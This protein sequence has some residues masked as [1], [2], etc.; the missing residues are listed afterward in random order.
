[1]IPRVVYDTN[2]IIS[3]LFWS[4][5]SRRLLKLAEQSKVILFSSLDTE[6]ELVRVLQYSKFGLSFEESLRFLIYYQSISARIKVSTKINIIDR[7]PSDNIFLE[8]AIDSFA[9]YIVSGDH[10]LLDLGGY[11]EIKII[12]AEQFL[13]IVKL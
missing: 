12:T 9:N 4:G 13:K 7:D 10:H 8:C 3:G 11:K 6:R 1:M 5:A 2:I